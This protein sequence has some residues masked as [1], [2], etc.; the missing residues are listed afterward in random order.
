MCALLDD[1]GGTLLD[2]IKNLVE[3]PV[4]W[5]YD[6]YRAM[7][8]FV[9]QF[10]SPRPSSLGQVALGLHLHS[11][12]DPFDQPFFVTAIRRFAKHLCVARAKFIDRHPPQR[13]QF[14]PNV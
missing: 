10:R 4:L 13:G 9:R 7:S 5:G 12:D 8:A 11:V 1:P 3:R 6:R 2:A 14:F